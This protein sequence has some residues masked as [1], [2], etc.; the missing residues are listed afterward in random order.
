MPI[1]AHED[2]KKAFT[3]PT[4]LQ[5]KSILTRYS[6]TFS[7]TNSIFVALTLRILN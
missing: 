5:K 6:F 3:P 2:T 4:Y 1:L 7:L